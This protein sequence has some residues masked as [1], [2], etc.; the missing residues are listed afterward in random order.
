MLPDDIV[1]ETILTVIAKNYPSP[2]ET[3]HAE[4]ESLAK[5]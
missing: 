1:G 4:E 3:S 5:M 2:I